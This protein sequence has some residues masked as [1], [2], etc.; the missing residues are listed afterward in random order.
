MDEQ[1]SEKRMTKQ[2]VEERKSRQVLARRHMLQLSSMVKQ[3]EQL[4]ED[5]ANIDLVK[6]TLRV[7]FSSCIKNSPTEILV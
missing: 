7:D 2:A 1:D 5:N 3:I 4:M 6:N